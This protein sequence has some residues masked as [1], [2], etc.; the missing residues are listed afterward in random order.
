MC[1]LRLVVRGGAALQLR[2]E[3]HHRALHKS[4]ILHLT[5]HQTQRHE[6]I[7]QVMQGGMTLTRVE[8]SLG[9]TQLYLLHKV[10]LGIKSVREHERD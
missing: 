6:G 9:C 1:T 10:I 5:P 4:M 3:H 7:H 2:R 8:M